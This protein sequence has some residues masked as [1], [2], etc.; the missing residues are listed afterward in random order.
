MHAP[1]SC[2]SDP[3]RKSWVLVLQH[4]TGC[5][6]HQRRVL[7]SWPA[8][9]LPGAASCEHSS[10]LAPGH[11][12]VTWI[13]C[14][15]GL[16]SDIE[17]RVV[18]FLGDPLLLFNFGCNQVISLSYGTAWPHR[19]WWNFG[20]GPETLADMMQTDAANVSVCLVHL[21][22]LLLSV[23]KKHF[24]RSWC[25]FSSSSTQAH[26]EWIWT[27]LA[28]WVKC[29]FPACPATGDRIKVVSHA[30]SFADTRCHC[31]PEAAWLLCVSRSVVSDSLQTP[32]TGD[33]QAPPSMEFSR[34]EHWSG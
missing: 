15:C 23:I 22:A 30:V 8:G 31:W 11:C 28:A 5:A 1:A 14:A 3:R 18:S 6:L 4:D 16:F 17:S 29:D 24:L 12:W 10:S 19:E 33:L 13:W 7:W 21:L 32:W 9:T 34:Q 26:V 20:F 27:Q 25:S 2:I